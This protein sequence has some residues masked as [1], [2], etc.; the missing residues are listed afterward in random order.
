MRIMVDATS[1][2]LPSAGVKTYL[3][4]W[5]SA[6][7]E[8]SLETGDVVVTYPPAV[9]LASLLDHEDSAMRS[10]GA[11]VQLRLVQ[12]NNLGWGLGWNPLVNLAVIGAALFHCSQH[13]VN[14]PR[15]KPVTATIFDFSCWTTPENHT[16]ENIAATRRYGDQILKRCDGLIAISNHARNDAVA[17]LGIPAERI[18]V[19]YPGVADM[20]YRATEEHADIV[21]SKHGLDTPY[22]LFVGCIEPRK[23]IP[24]LLQAF[25]RVRESFSKDVNLVIAG[26]FGWEMESLRRTLT[27]EG[28]GVRYLGYVP[29]N[30][31]PGLFRGASAFAFPSFYEGFG[32]PVA[33]AM[34]S[35]VPVIIS[36]RAALPEI[37]AGNG[38]TVDPD[39]VEELAAAIEKILDS[40]SLSAELARR[41][42]I[43]SEAFRWA[44]SAADSL[45]FFHDVAGG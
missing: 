44:G 21:R 25:A 16:A 37:A 22:V 36:D 31:L 30:D 39:S 43:R 23:N 12:F 15:Q 4:Y 3:H 28:S 6:M 45:R 35:G 38:L 32:L 17:F 26:P 34:A 7:R 11:L 41:G 2:L 24:K 8:A 33:Q 29:E 42:R 14:L 13:T 27:N 5:L 18:R 1:L 19:I 10:F 9:R 20:F 40:P